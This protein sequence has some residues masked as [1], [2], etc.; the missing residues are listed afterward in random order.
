MRFALSLCIIVLYAGVQGHH[1]KDHTDTSEHLDSEKHDHDL[2]LAVANADFAFNLYHQVASDKGQTN[3]FFSPVS[4]STAFAMLSLA[5][6]SKTYSQITETLGFNE[7]VLTEEDIHE[8]FHRLIQK[9]NAADSELQLSMGNAV[10]QQEKLKFLAKFLQ[11]LTSYEAQAFTADFHNTTEAIKQIND[12]VEKQTHGKIVDMMKD[13]DPRTLL[14]LVNYIYFK[15]KWEKPFEADRTTEE[16]FHVDENTV[17]R[18]PMMVRSGMYDIYHD[19]ESHSTI[20]RLPYKGNA[21]AYLILPENGKMKQVE[22]AFSKETLKMWKSKL[23][24]SSVDLHFPKFS[25]SATLDLKSTLMK[26]GIIDIFSDEADLSGITGQRDIKVSEAV[27][28]AAINIDETGTEAAGVTTIEIMPM[29][30]PQTLEIN[31]PFLMAI[32][33]HVTHTIIFM[34]K[35]VNPTAQ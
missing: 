19:E 6:R 25:T 30:L 32:C 28:K 7:T 33:E 29:S 22:T 3:I 31:R 23:R 8:S 10:F 20:V 12:Y 26:M 21:S 27:H 1:H 14:V 4:V 24:R 9:L 35:I 17:V 11:D 13:I 16:D 5:A 15:G 2:K 18:V 34:G